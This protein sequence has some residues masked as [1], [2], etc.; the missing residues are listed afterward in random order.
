[1][2][3]K[4]SIY[5][6]N[7]KFQ[8]RLCFFISSLVFI[9]SLIYPLTIYELFRNLT[10]QIGNNSPSIAQAFANNK[11]NLIAI[12]AVYQLSFIAVVFM[13]CIFQGHKIAGPMY[14]VKKSLSEIIE[15]KP[16]PLIV[17]RKDDHFLE[18]ANVLNEVFIKIKNDHNKD[19]AYI[20]EIN[21]Y[22]RNLLFVIPDDKKVVLQEIIN[23][24]DEIQNRFKQ[25]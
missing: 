13:V 19:F 6:I 9:L 16:I 3:Y 25:I 1:M 21:S 14:K 10:V 5:L 17:F 2:W 18:I 24:L 4:R 23:K 11:L 15:G 8:L 12:L 7:P 22:I 20:S